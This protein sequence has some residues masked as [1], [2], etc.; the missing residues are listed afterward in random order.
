[1]KSQGFLFTMKVKKGGTAMK[2]EKLSGCALVL[3]GLPTPTSSQ[4]SWK[5][6]Q[7]GWA[8]KPKSKRRGLPI[9]NELTRE[10]L[11][12][13]SLIILANDIAISGEERFEGYEAKTV[14]SSMHEILH[15][16]HEVIER[17]FEKEG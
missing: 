12:E 2:K 1:M 17:F 4:T 11:N 9:E 3:Q 5:A 14:H 13:A 8:T 16:A 10:D 6:K 7:S 15:H